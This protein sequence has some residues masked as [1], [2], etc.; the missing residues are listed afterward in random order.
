MKEFF[1]IFVKNRVYA[2]IMMVFAVICGAWAM[3]NLPKE[4][5]PDIRMDTVRVT[6]VWPGADPAE[7]EEGVSCKVEEAIEGVEGIKN[8]HTLSNE[9]VCVADIEVLEGY[10][11][12]KVKDDIR[13]AVDA[14]TTFPPDAERPVVE[15]FMI[16]VQVLLLAVTCPNLSTA[17]LQDYAQKIKDELIALPSVSQVKLAERDRE[18]I[19]EVSE[20][21]LREYGV[22][23]E[24]VAQVIKANS[25]NAPG[26][27]I[28]TEGEHIRLRTMGRN[29]TAED[30]S[31]IVVL[32]RPEGYH[33]T[34]DRIATIQ[35]GFADNDIVTRF[36][37]KNAVILHLLKTDEED[38]LQ[39]DQDVRDYCERKN[40]ELPEGMKIEPW[41]RFAPLLQSRINLL[42]KNGYMG[43][44][45]VFVLLWLYLDIRLSFWTT[46]N[47]PL[48][49]AGTFIVMHYYDVTLN[50]ITMFGMVMVLGIVVDNSMIIGEAI[51]VARK[52]G[53]PPV[54]AAVEGVAE[55]AMPIIASTTTNMVS[56]VPLLFVPGFVGRLAGTLPIVTIAAFIFSLLECLFMFPAHL[57]HL[58]DMSAPDKGRNFV[59]RMGMLFH[60][61]TNHGL[62]QFIEKRYQPFVNWTLRWRYVTA[63][64]AIAIL[65]LAAGV[66]SGGFVKVDFFPLID[67]NSMS[68]VVEFPSG[69]TMA[70]TTDAVVRIEEAARRLQD[71]LT[72]ATGEP[73]LHNV[74][75][76]TG[77]HL[78]ERGQINLGTH[79]G[80]V[81]VE[82]LDSVARGIHITKMMAE[83]EKEVGALNGAIAFTIRGDETTSP[84]G[85]PVD[86]WMKGNDLDQLAAAASELKEKLGTYDGVY[87]IKDDFRI[88]KK[89]INLRLKPEARALGL[90]AYDLAKH[91]F[92]GYFGEELMRVQRGDNNLRI[93]LRYPEDERTQVSELEKIRIPVSMPHQG[94]FTAT[95]MNEAKMKA[96]GAGLP[97]LPPKVQEVPLTSVADL[98]YKAGVS[99][100][101]RTNGQRR[102]AVSA[103]MDTSQANSNE[104]VAELKSGFLQSLVHKYPGLT[105]SF[106]GEQQ[107]FRE[108]LD[109]LKI[110]YPLALMGIFVLVA[111][112]FRSYIQTIV[113]MVAVP[114]GSA[115]AL[116]GHWLFGYDISI[117]SILG[118]VALS[119]V[120][121]NDSIVLVD[122][123]N[124]YVA[125][126][127]NFFEAV[128]RAG[129]RRFRAIFLTTITTVGGLGPLML[130]QDS[131]AQM[132]IPMALSMSAGVGFSMI[133]SLLITPCTLCI[134]NDGRRAMY[135]LI[136]GQWPTPEE[137]EP[138]RYRDLI[139]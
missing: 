11:I 109:Y 129:V 94:V 127:E 63:S 32:S 31:K 112:S 128:G 40:K 5:F 14:I 29:Y 48:A 25:L 55:V 65:L 139:E 58:P 104:I 134:I 53:L 6:V 131:Q 74:F 105:L 124:T 4:T 2:N 64:I 119:G 12:D 125:N 17:E 13:T 76:L 75:S 16:R 122:C 78:D 136:H 59:A 49:F 79:F 26:G 80:T 51:Y 61:Y 120:V 85:R 38:T 73:L 33:L 108:A 36:N 118:L 83:W 43:L 113:V 7:V 15:E 39:I 130:E 23:F 60:R 46:V 115:A 69:T 93:R 92:T 54:K 70:V 95:A 89:E 77:A 117:M 135:W 99:S 62:E 9:H 100:I 72:T 81:R 18:I 82:L 97:T 126:G 47:V 116:F 138:A 114:F 123:V 90:H 52:R 107:D 121:V 35:D 84:P 42:L 8:Y 106:E 37:G 111:A 3:V 71:K 22:T 110:G 66:Y 98:E 21:K 41:A 1:T 28:R 101:Q 30:F 19:I 67:G 27:T 96:G 102:V 45:V 57:N 34:L 56:F 44:L 50:M 24:Q 86:I 68:A 20:E 91:I 88:G 132:L 10:D 103:E 137:V 133:V 87:Q